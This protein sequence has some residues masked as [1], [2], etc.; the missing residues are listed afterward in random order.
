VK[1]DEEKN[2]KR[3]EMLRGT[4]KAALLQNSADT[5]DLLAASVYDTKPVHLMSTVSKSVRWVMKN[6]KVWSKDEE[7]MKVIGFLRLNMI[8]DYN[9]NMNS[10]DIADQLRNTYRPDHWMRNRKWW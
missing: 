1:Q 4:T 9:Q 5:P 7:A 8:D 6:K 10:T 3:A 2:V